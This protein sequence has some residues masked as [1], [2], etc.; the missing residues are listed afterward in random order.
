MVA[1]VSAACSGTPA[2][3]TTAPAPGSSAAAT[4][5]VNVTIT[6]AGCVPDK[7]SVPAGTVT[8]NATNQGADAVDELELKQGEHTV[9]EKENLTPGLSGSFTA[10]LAAG[11]YVLECPGATTDESEFTVN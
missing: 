10:T 4:S 11:S 9:A 2:A 3:A 6:P 8:F 5:T 1:A 7:A